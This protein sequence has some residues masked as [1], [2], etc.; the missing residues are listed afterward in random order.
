MYELKLAGQYTSG[1]HTLIV[2]TRK[3]TDLS[4]PY[5]KSIEVI[6]QPTSPAM[7]AGYSLG[8]L[9]VF[10]LHSLQSSVGR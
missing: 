7:I 3:Q 10:T 1:T 2:I 6:V 8:A 5:S 4:G 9:A